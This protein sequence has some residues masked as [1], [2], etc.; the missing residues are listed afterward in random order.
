[1]NDSRDQLDAAIDR[2]ATR[3]V[4][5][6][7]DGLTTDRIASRLP[8]RFRRGLKPSPSSRINWSWL[9][10]QLAAAAGVALLAFFLFSN[11]STEV[12]DKTATFDAAAPDA[13]DAPDA[14]A[15]PD[16]PVAPVA[17]VA[18]VVPAVRSASAPR[19]TPAIAVVD[20]SFDRDFGLDPIVRPGQI[21]ISAIAQ[22]PA[23]DVPTAQVAP[24]VL[25]DLPL[26]SESPS[27]R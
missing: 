8:E 18:R 12:V 25:T 24:I 3:L 9:A 4:S 16:T 23:I 7:P 21:V 26:A 5:V 11:R 6:Q 27:P 14:P 20:D 2:V 19:K 17:T 13:P 10:P 1:M 15:A 22:A